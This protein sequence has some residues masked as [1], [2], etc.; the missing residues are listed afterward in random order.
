M[1]TIDDPDLEAK[2]RALA[3]TTGEPPAVVA[4]RA[5]VRALGEHA[6]ASPRTLSPEERAR[7]RAILLEHQ[8][9]MARLPEL[10]PRSADEII[11]YDEHGLPT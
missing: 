9:E 2:L 5:L 4:R 11:G 7:R 10:D 1:I 6:P 8:E 3:A